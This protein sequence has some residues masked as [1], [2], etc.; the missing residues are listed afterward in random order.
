[1]IK[2]KEVG[3]VFGIKKQARKPCERGGIGEQEGEKY[4]NKAECV[5]QALSTGEK[6]QIFRCK[7]VCAVQTSFS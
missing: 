6:N 1:M 7:Q 4:K 3:S 5:G 2:T